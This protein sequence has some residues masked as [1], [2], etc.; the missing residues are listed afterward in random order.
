MCVCVCTCV[1]VCVCVHILH[2]IIYILSLH[3]IVLLKDYAH[4]TVALY[5]TI[6]ISTG[7]YK[8]IV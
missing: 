7:L 6:V 5:G 8:Y 2:S 4:I 3:Y 1:C